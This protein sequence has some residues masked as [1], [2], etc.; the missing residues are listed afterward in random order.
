VK[1]I[2]NNTS[3]PIFCDNGNCIHVGQ[4]GG[5][6]PSCRQLWWQR[7]SLMALVAAAAAWRQQRLLGGSVATA[8]AWRRQLGGGAAALLR[9]PAF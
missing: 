5:S 4:L 1:I 8:A 3:S 2:I 7:N 9:V 6:G